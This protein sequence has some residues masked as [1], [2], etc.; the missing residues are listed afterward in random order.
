MKKCLDCPEPPAQHWIRCQKCAYEY[1]SKLMAG[2]IESVGCFH[3]MPRGRGIRG[4]RTA[5]ARTK[6]TPPERKALMTKARKRWKARGSAELLTKRARRAKRVGGSTES[7][8]RLP[9][10]IADM[11]ARDGF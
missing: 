8:S 4:E 10:E 5:T 11:L 2:K 6:L 3:Y 1:C 9:N 7:A